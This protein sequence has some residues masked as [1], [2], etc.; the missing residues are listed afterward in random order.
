MSK[1]SICHNVSKEPGEG[2]MN[3]FP[4]PYKKGEYL[5]TVF[6]VSLKQ[7]TINSLTTELLLENIVEKRG[8][9]SKFLHFP[10]CFPIC[11][12]IVHHVF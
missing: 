8:N 5:V 12:K 7:T 10:P 6:N 11:V 2:L 1:F 9:C 4:S 3:H